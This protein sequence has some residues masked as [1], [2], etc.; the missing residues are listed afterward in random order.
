M[1]EGDDV[2]NFESLLDAERVFV[3][4]FVKFRINSKADAE[5]VL[6]E[7]FLSAYQKF[8]QLKNKE[9]F[10]AWIISIARNKCNDYFRKYLSMS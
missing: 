6:Q 8:P 3:Q 10:K 2:D 5:D 7:V 4:R 1:K 9:A